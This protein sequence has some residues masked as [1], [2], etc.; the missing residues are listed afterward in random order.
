MTLSPIAV[1]WLA[2]GLL[3][4]LSV[5]FVVGASRYRRLSHR[6]GAFTCDY[7][8]GRSD[9]GEPRRFEPGVAVYSAESLD[10]YA[11]LSLSPAYQH[12][13]S[14][15]DLV[16]RYRAPAANRNGEYLVR[17]QCDGAEFDLLM[18][19]A[20]YL[21]LASWLEAAPPRVPTIL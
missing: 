11:A 6:I 17:C 2:G 10:W 15:T 3:L 19:A 20:A 16:V 4:I 1:L 5:L 18:P 8:S 14:R 12:R 21:G 7:R 9:G 13:W